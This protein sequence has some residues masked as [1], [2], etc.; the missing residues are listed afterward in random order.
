MKKICSIVNYFKLTVIMHMNRVQFGNA[1]CIHGR[2]YSAPH[3]L[4]IFL[5]VIIFTFHLLAIWKYAWLVHDCIHHVVHWT[6]TLTMY[7]HFPDYWQWYCWARGIRC[8]SDMLITLHSHLVEG[9]LDNMV[10]LQWISWGVAIMFS[11][12]AQLIHIPTFGVRRVFF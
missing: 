9:L 5:L 3:I 4:N 8:R 7:I 6:E 1:I 10:F 11:V 2:T 12:M